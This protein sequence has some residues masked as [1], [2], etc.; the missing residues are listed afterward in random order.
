[1]Y[2]YTGGA[3]RHET[4]PMWSMPRVPVTYRFLG[5]SIARSSVLKCSAP[6]QPMCGSPGS[7][8]A[9]RMTEHVWGD[10]CF[11]QSAY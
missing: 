10:G 9:L 6:P 4:S 8:K 2:G 11:E 5:Y 1:M 3:N 7:H